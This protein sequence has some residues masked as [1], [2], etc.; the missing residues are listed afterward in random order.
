MG[1]SARTEYCSFTKAV[2]HLGDRWSLLIVRE[3]AMFGPQGFN[4]LAAGLPGRI[5]RSVLAARMRK[6]CELGIVARVGPASAQAAPYRLTPGGTQL[7]PTLE[8]LW[9][10]ADHWIPE[11]PAMARRDPTVILWWLLQRIDRRALPERPVAIE[12]GLL[13]D[14]GDRHWLLLADAA[15]PELCD[16]DP[17]IGEDRYVHVVAE[18][19][20]LEPIARGQRSW[21][22]ALADGSVELFGDPDL[23]L[24]LPGWFTGPDAAHPR[25]SLAAAG[26]QA[27]A[28]DSA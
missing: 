11:D 5:S 20:A 7:V 24:Q 12:L 16:E 21:E 15:E 14:G 9:R 22:A 6:L 3:L 26:R 13:V 27:V 8:S 23:V 4:T 19:A 28:A 25:T 18:A 10:W 17:L 1:S 2:E